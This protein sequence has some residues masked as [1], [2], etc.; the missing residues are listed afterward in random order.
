MSDASTP[1]STAEWR[2]GWLAARE[3][4]ALLAEVYSEENFRLA[5]DA[6]LTDPVL[7]RDFSPHAFEVSQTLMIQGAAHS[8]AGH[9]AQHIADAIRAKEPPHAE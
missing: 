9:T 3:A 2:A 1:Q 7:K 5:S 6:V 4:F 8:S